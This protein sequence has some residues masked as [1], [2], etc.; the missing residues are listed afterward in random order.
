MSS[1]SGRINSII[2]YSIIM[3]TFS[4]KP[5]GDRVVVKPEAVPAEASVSGIIVQT[6]DTARPLCGEVVA[7]G[8][9]KRV[10]GKIQ[11]MEVEVGDKVLFSR[12]G[13][14]E[15]IV[16]GQLYYIMPEAVVIA[17]MK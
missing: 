8:S 13:W 2:I 16:N 11:K 15:T 1:E 17:I 9:G 7:V 6:K 3:S 5:L 14:D 12:F 10:P 4:L